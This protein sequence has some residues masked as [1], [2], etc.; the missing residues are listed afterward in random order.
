MECVKENDED[1]GVLTLESMHTV[2]ET[3]N[4]MD[5]FLKEIVT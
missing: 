2:V 3:S 1:L 5:Y 4:L